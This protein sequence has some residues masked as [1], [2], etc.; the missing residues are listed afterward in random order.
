M[1]SFLNQ[2]LGFAKNL[3]VAYLFVLVV[4]YIYILR[5]PE[6]EI[7]SFLPDDAFYT[8]SLARNFQSNHVWTIGNSAEG[9]G[10]HILPTFRFMAFYQISP[11][12]EFKTLWAINSAVAILVFCGCFFLFSR[13][14][15]ARLNSP[16]ISL[17][18]MSP[19]F[20]IEVIEQTTNLME[21][22]L[23]VLMLTVL[24]VNMNTT[25]DK[26]WRNYLTYAFLLITPLVR[27]DI[28][29]IVATLLVVSFLILT[30]DKFMKRIKQLILYFIF[31]L[32]GVL[33]NALFYLSQ[34]GSLSSSS[35]RAKF[36]YSQQ[37]GHDVMRIIWRILLMFCNYFWQ[38]DLRN[39][40]LLS[41]SLILI[42]TYFMSSHIS[43][44]RPKID[45]V[46]VAGPIALL[47]MI[48]VYKYNSAG[49]FSWYNA[50]LL[51]PVSTTL[52]LVGQF[53]QI[54]YPHKSLRL[55]LLIHLFIY[56]STV[57]SKFFSPIWTDH[58]E[59]Y[60]V[61][62]YLKSDFD[63]DAKFGSWNTGILAYF[64]D[65]RFYNL[66]GLVNDEMLIHLSSGTYDQYLIETQIKYVVDPPR[67]AFLLNWP[68]GMNERA[69]SLEK[70]LVPIS[71]QL[72]A[73]PSNE[74]ELFEVKIIRTLP[75]WP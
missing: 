26:S 27:I 12:V 55:I 59:V 25:K 74:V 30:E 16:L 53:L 73:W 6:E 51:I 15:N 67:I 54:Y 50:V 5:L 47:I 31:L 2:R 56:T 40:F 68:E 69:E 42:I 17:L 44:Q 45:P 35:S 38:V 13:M 63:S 21:A 18:V 60:K 14:V 36:F 71:D 75:K 39:L 11:D 7:V 62:Q 48:V 23:V 33:L 20:S 34:F 10:F 58:S 8:L 41:A 24:F 9:S 46:V 72:P 65:K 28:T 64:S 19:W 29:A 57:S 43:V 66:D 49:L 22:D 1:P 3:T 37:D 4:R 52:L 32:A 70:M 61:A